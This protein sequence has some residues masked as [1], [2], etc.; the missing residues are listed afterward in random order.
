[1]LIDHTGMVALVTGGSSGIG[2]ETARMLLETGADVAICGRD[3]ERLAAA[4]KSLGDVS[5]GGDLLARTCDVL[6]PEQVAELAEAVRERFGRLDMLICNAGQGRTSTFADTSDADWRDELELKFFSV[7]H[8]VRAFQAMLTEADAGSIVCVN[9]LLARQPEPHMVA[10]SA[11]RAGLLNLVRSLATELA[12]H[13]IR[14]NSVLLGLVDSGQWRRRYEAR[15]ADDQS[16][17]DWM[18]DLARQKNIP[19]GRLG[20]P[21]EPA[22]AIVFLASP[23]ASYTTGAAIDV[24]GGLSRHV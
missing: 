23:C 6:D 4:V 18:A 9:S 7:I 2:L 20:R 3:P 16:Y 10:T 1:M 15:A 11:A 22:R 17:E 13:G 8:P 19:L 12:P 21:D 24:S 5:G 14:V